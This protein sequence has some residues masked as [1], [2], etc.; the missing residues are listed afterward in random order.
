MCPGWIL[1]IASFI[2][3]NYFRLSYCLFTHSAGTNGQKVGKPLSLHLKTDCFFFSFFHGTQ[4]QI[5]NHSA[6]MLRAHPPG[7]VLYVNQHGVLLHV[8][9]ISHQQQL[10]QLLV[11]TCSEQR[12]TLG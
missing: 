5:I 8:E 7:E 10:D 2:K 3:W 6:S 4:M 1:L 12:Q 9:L 11:Q